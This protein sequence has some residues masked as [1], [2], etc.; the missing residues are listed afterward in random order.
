VYAEALVKLVI[1]LKSKNNKKRIGDDKTLFVAESVSN[2]G[3]Q[4]LIDFVN[5]SPVNKDL[6]IFT[7]TST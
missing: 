4:S 2:V 6:D 7:I 3:L 1:S 5:H